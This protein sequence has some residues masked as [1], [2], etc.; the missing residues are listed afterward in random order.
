MAKQTSRILDYR[1]API[2]TSLLTQELSAGSNVTGVR[3]VFRWPVSFSLTPEKLASIL[4]QVDQGNIIEYLTMAEEMEERDLH[5]AS[6][7]GK[8]KLAVAG[9]E[10][11]VEPAGPDKKSKM[12]ADAL[13]ELVDDLAFS[14]LLPD[15]L[16]ALG[17]SFSATEIMW[18]KSGAQWFPKEYKHR[19]PRFFRFDYD[20]MDELRLI[21]MADMAFGIPLPAYKFVQHRPRIKCG[22]PIRGGLARLCCFIYMCKGF[23]LKDWMTFAEVYGMP[24][25]L[26]KYE[27]GATN[28][29]KE[30]L[31]MAAMNLGTDAAA[32]IPNTMM[33]E[34]IASS[35]A[36]NG[37]PLFQGLTDWLDSQTS[38]GI[39]GQTMSADSK[40][41]GIGSGN[42]DL[43]GEVRHDIRDFDALQLTA[44][45]N[46]DVGEPF[47]NLNFGAQERYPK[48]SI[49]AIESEDLS[50]LALSLPAFID[51]GL[52]VKASADSRKV[53]LEEPDDGDELLEPVAKG[54]PLG[55][56]RPGRKSDRAS[57]RN[58][59]ATVAITTSRSR[60][61]TASVS[62][63]KGEP[64]NVDTI[65]PTKKARERLTE[66]VLA[67]ATLT[68]D[69]RVLLA[70]LTAH[71]E[72]DEIDRL[73]DAALKN[74][75]HVSDPLLGQFLA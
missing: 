47:V 52:K 40:A 16:D 41:S 20:S 61:I 56:T 10:R 35:S 63:V 23:A 45:L 51:R 18:D 68:G 38:K 32:I 25:R 62:G 13:Q 73:A 70:A 14:Q 8:R 75:K 43:H 59:P 1:G 29:Q 50:S 48:I 17:K 24:L 74:S 60:P 36:T 11:H 22:I 66:M 46:R 30:A 64:K 67:G 7:L 27:E 34:I 53:H 33:L 42:A 4:R 12:I 54:A 55:Q 49:R 37:A 2:E 57:W 58:R 19:D 3:P 9:L 72:T 69:Q 31:L 26:G 39:L 44:T 65:N 15:A 21:D 6:E 5:Y 71:H 28:E